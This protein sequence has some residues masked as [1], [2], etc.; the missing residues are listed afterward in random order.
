MCPQQLI[1]TLKWMD[2][3]MANII[4]PM[5]IKPRPNTYTFTKA[6]AEVKYA[7]SYKKIEMFQKFIYHKSGYKK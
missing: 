3:D 4:T 1:D 2:N 7:F 5:L 6:L